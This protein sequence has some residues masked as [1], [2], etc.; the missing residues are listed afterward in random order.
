MN[1]TNRS[2]YSYK[3]LQEV[4]IYGILIVGTDVTTI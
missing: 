3:I 4:N 2:Y 1:V